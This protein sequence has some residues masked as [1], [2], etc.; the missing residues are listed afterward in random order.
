MVTHALQM[1]RPLSR[2]TPS[3]HHVPAIEGK[4]AG[5]S[6]LQHKIGKYGACDIMNEKY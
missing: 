1:S 3:S 2:Q 4:P 6:Y 5:V